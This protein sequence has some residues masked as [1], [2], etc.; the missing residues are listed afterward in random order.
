MSG[1][2]KRGHPGTCPVDMGMPSKLKGSRSW[3]PLTGA[4]WSQSPG[5]RAATF[6]LC[7]VRPGP[8]TT[9]LKPLLMEVSLGKEA[10]MGERRWEQKSFTTNPP[11][12]PTHTK[13]NEIVGVNNIADP[14]TAPS[15]KRET[16]VCSSY[17]NCFQVT[18]VAHCCLST[19]LGFLLLP[20][21]RVVH[22]SRGG[23]A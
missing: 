8:K 17:W 4:S 15:G 10:K 20:C 5:P 6:S 16:W 12:L 2:E 21:S 22:C 13:Y 11:P 1:M 23:P 3:V 18:D 19:G 7:R 14:D 9:D